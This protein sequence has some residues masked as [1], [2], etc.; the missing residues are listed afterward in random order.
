MSPPLQKPSM[1]SG[2]T[3][4]WAHQALQIQSGIVRIKLPLEAKEVENPVALG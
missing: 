4:S 3:T 1:S 2:S